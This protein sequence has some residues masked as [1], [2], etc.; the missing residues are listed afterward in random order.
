MI[1]RIPL[2]DNIADPLTKPLAQEVFKY[3]YRTMGL[4]HKVIGFSPGRR[5]ID[6]M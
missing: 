3:N 1:D 2:A 6:I 4:M 5:L